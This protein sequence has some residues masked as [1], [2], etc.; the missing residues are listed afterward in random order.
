L[1]NLND[2]KDGVTMT[3]RNDFFSRF[4]HISNKNILSLYLWE[5]ELYN[6]EGEEGLIM[7]TVK[8]GV[9]TTVLER[10]SSLSCLSTFGRWSLTT[11]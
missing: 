6:S 5:E 4:R 8:M 7:K 3:M 1:K 11:C 9:L 2:C 10:L